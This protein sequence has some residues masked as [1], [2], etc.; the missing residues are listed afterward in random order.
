[1]YH[2]LKTWPHSFQEI[3]EGR[4]TAE[5]RKNDRDFRV[6]DLIVLSEYEPGE[7]KYTGRIILVEVTNILQAESLGMPRGYCVMSIKPK[8]VNHE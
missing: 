8:E 4:K 2:V 6:N 1:M 5:F 3:L 7:K